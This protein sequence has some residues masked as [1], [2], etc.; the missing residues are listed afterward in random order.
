MAILAAA[1]LS[2]SC[3]LYADDASK[4]A[5]IEELFRVM[6]VDQLQTQMMD[7]MRTVMSNMFD[8][9]GVPADLKA[10]RKE[11]EDEVFAVIR[12]RVSW[13]RLKN[14]YVKIY[15]DSLTEPEVDSILAFYK[16]PGGIA[17]L[18]KLPVI[19]KKSMELGQ[20]QMKD[21]LPEIQQAVEKFMERHKA[22]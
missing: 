18:E 14:D 7:Q 19:T 8:Q 17:L 5:K 6:R 13:E 1:A 3:T 22:K 21:A 15:A 2:A 12:R 10:S 4:N 16:T 11:L 20:A 9:A